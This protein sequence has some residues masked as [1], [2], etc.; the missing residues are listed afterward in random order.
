MPASDFKLCL[1]PCLNCIGCFDVIWLPF[2][3]LP[4]AKE[5]ES[6]LQQDISLLELPSDEWSIAVGCITCGHVDDYDVS[7]VEPRVVL[8]P[9]KGQHHSDANFVFLEFP[10]LRENLTDPPFLRNFR[11]PLHRDEPTLVT[12]IRLARD[13]ERRFCREFS[14]E[15]FLE[16]EM[17]DTLD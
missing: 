9:A 8:K 16:C 3:N 17:F 4:E 7:Y 13:S 12:A 1:S 5:N 10:A 14:S 11:N 6:I 2:P 15:H